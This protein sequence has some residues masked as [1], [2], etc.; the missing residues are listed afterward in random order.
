MPEVVV[1]AEQVKMATIY[2]YDAQYTFPEPVVTPP[3]TKG[4]LTTAVWKMTSRCPLP[5]WIVRY[6]LTGGPQAIFVPSGSNAVEVLT[7]AAGRA[8]VEIVQKDPSPGTS[9]VRVQLFH[10]A[11]QNGPRFLVRDGGTAVSWTEGAVAAATPT[12]PVLPGSSQCNSVPVGPVHSGPADGSA[13]AVGDT[14]SFGRHTEYAECF[15]AKRDAAWS[16]RF[17]A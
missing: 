1:P 17:D 8:S 16:G 13:S 3:G 14:A 11:D 15:S 7:D 9:Q 2:W 6:E 5:G 10:P 4:M 12:A